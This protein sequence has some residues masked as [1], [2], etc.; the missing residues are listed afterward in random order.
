MNRI[1]LLRVVQGVT[2]LDHVGIGSKTAVDVWE[3]L[4]DGNPEEI[5]SVS[6]KLPGRQVIHLRS[7]V[8]YRRRGGISNAELYR[9]IVGMH[10][11]TPGTDLVFETAYNEENHSVTYTFLGELRRF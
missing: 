2:P 10:L 6:F 9:W 11:G 8:N 3:E 5:T 1:V 7:L 4:C